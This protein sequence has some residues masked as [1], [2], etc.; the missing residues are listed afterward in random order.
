[1]DELQKITNE[2]AI[3]DFDL[4]ENTDYAH[5]REQLQQKIISLLL[6]NLPAL[7][8]ILYRIDVNEHKVK[9]L[10][11]GNKPELIAPGLTDLILER[12]KQ[13]AETRL[14]YKG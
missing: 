3:K 5:L 7:W 8:N 9:Q 1:M 6:N 4:P 11:E 10:F 12:F 13:K 14:K 2:L